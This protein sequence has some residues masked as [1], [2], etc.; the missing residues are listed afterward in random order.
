VRAPDVLFHHVDGEGEPVLLLNGVA[1][2]VAG[3][4]PIAG[5]LARHYSV[6]RCDFRG[7]LM[8]PEEPPDDVAEHAADVVA[9][10]DHLEVDGAHLV[11]TSYGGVIG[12]LVA[13]RWPDRVWSLVSIASADGFDDMMAVEVA[14]WREACLLSLQGPDRGLLSDAFEGAVYSPAYL[15][16]HRA[17][18][19]ERRRQVAALPDT[20]FHGLA[21]LLDHAPSISIRGELDKVRCP[22]LIVAAELDRFVPFDRTRSLARRI[23]GAR[24]VLMEG[25]GHAVVVEQPD[26]VVEICLEFL[27]SLEKSTGKSE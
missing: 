16:S 24:F 18:R 11:G 5:P 3:W 13:A 2:S 1:M 12:T 19:A 4:Q 7:Q 22:T 17:E 21:G 10:L 26:K 20:W 14:R 15:E 25:A 9:L 6:I 8:T 27:E 23:G